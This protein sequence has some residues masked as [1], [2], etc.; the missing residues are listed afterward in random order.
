M[1]ASDPVDDLD[2]KPTAMRSPKPLYGYVVA[3]ELIVVSILNLT[4]THG[5]GAPRIPDRPW[6]W[7]A[8][9][10]RS[11][12]S[13]SSAPTTASS[14]LAGRHRRAFFVTLPEVP[15]SL[16]VY[17]S[18]AHPGDLRLRADPAAAP[19][20]HR[21]GGRPAGADSA[22]P[23][24]QGPAAAQEPAPAGPAPAAAGR[25]TGANQ[26]DPQASR[27]TPRPRPSASSPP[28]SRPTGPRVEAGLGRRIGLGQPA[29]PGTDDPR[30]HTW[31]RSETWGQRAPGPAG[32]SAE[33]RKAS[34]SARRRT[35]D[36]AVG[37][38]PSGPQYLHL[39]GHPDHRRV[40][41]QQQ[42]AGVLPAELAGG[43][44][45]SRKPV[46]RSMNGPQHLPEPGRRRGAQPAD[47]AQ[48]AQQ[49]GAPTG[50]PEHR[51]HHGVHPR[52]ALAPPD[53]AFSS[54]AM[55]S[56]PASSMTA[57]SRASLEA[58]W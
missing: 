28:A 39:G 40:G 21:P 34:S 55:S 56:A 25:R 22:R 54:T 8:W 19:G 12:W 13:G 24:H 29:R 35:S 5:N 57:S 30:P 38:T 37:S 36:R 46:A 42:Q 50:Q 41:G 58:K 3:A 11:P 47:L 4:V 49:L 6:R 43:H 33:R 20:G 32:S 45:S 17:I 26:T 7:S 53:T 51:T 1:S 52:P 48:Q 27:A 31:R 14:C 10:P 15:N 44:A 2:L 16:A 9:S 23:P 18:W